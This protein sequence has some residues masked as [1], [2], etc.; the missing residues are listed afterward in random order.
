LSGLDP[1]THFGVLCFRVRRVSRPGRPKALEL[2]DLCRKKLQPLVSI[3]PK[4]YR[5]PA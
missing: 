5:V 1:V 2:L 3:V 4:V